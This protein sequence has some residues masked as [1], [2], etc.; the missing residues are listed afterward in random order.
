M[1]SALWLNNKSIWLIILRIYLHLGQKHYNF[2]RWTYIRCIHAEQSGQ[3]I[4]TYESSQWHQCSNGYKLTGQHC[5]NFSSLIY[6]SKN[7]NDNTWDQHQRQPNLQTNRK[8]NAEHAY[9]CLYGT[10]ACSQ[11]IYTLQYNS[12][13]GQTAFLIVDKVVCSRHGRITIITRGQGG[14]RPKILTLQIVIM[15]SLR[16]Y[17]L[18]KL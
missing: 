7:T 13:R 15:S 12:L 4:S 16:A 1:K 2:I 6:T 14:T 8:I 5:E 9:N 10:M 3:Y 18:C 11:S 17:I